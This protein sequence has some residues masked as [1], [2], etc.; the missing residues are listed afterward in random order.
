MCRVCASIR[1]LG[2]ENTAYVARIDLKNE[3]DL[4]KIAVGIAYRRISLRRDHSARLRRSGYRT[5]LDRLAERRQRAFDRFGESGG[6][7]TD[8]SG[9]RVS[10]RRRNAGNSGVARGWSVGT[11][12][13]PA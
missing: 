4:R 12:P 6:I 8:E 2:P 7:G 3:I 9:G 1:G 10:F 5:E 11:V 13:V